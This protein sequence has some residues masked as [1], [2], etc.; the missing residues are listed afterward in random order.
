MLYRH[1]EV[2]AGDLNSQ[3]GIPEGSRDYHYRIVQARGL[4]DEIRRERAP[5]GGKPER[6]FA[7]TDGGRE[8][9]ETWL[10]DT[11]EERPDGYAMRLE[12]AEEDIQDLRETNSRLEHTIEN[13][14]EEIERLRN[15]K[16]DEE[17]FEEFAEFVDTQMWQNILAEIEARTPDKT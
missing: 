13:Q 12:Q 6:V 4:V 9:T 16:L 7:L 10:V 11:D 8:F 1:G 3:I 14:A 17:R 5:T 15:D 2:R